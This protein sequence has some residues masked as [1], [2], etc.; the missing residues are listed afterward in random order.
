MGLESIRRRESIDLDHRAAFLREDLLP[1]LDAR[2]DEAEQQQERA[3]DDDVE[4]PAESPQELEGLRKRLAKQADD[5]ERVVDALDGDGV[6]VIQELM[7]DQTGLL[8]DDVAEQSVD[9]DQRTESVDVTPK[10][11]FHRN[12]TLQLAVVESPDEMKTVYD[13][14]LGREVID[15]TYMPDIIADYLFECVT[16][17]NDAGTVDGVGNSLSHYGVTTSDET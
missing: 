5:C 17:L 6:F 4:P 12:R 16:E 3:D 2:I 14:E 10:E 11:G 13:R 8:Q 15:L 9:I 1:D 7:A